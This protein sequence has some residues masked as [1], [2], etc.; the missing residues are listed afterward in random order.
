MRRKLNVKVVGSVIGVLLVASIGVH[1]LHGYQLKRNAYRL[2]ER[3]DQASA[4]KQDD[5]ALTCYQQYL[6]FAPNDADTLQK[7]VAVLDR[8]VGGE[9]VRLVLLMEQVLRAK[10]NEH[11]LRMRLVHNLIA[12]D[13]I[14]EALDHVVKLQAHWSDQAEY[15]HLLGWCQD[16]NKDHAKA[17]ESFAQAIRVNPKQIRSYALL[18][19]ILQDRLNQPDDAQKTIDDLVTANA[20]SYQA[21][22][23]RAR[24]LRRRGDDKSAQSDLA[25][26][27]KLGPDK[28]EVIFEIA[29]A[30]R[31]RGDWG[32]AVKLLKDGMKRFPDQVEF[33]RAISGVADNR[34]DAIEYLR[35]GLR[36]APQS[37]ELTILLI[38]LLIDQRQ[39]KE[40]RTKID[41][42]VKAGMKLALPNYLKARL[43]VAERE[44]SEAIRLLEGVREELGAGSEW[45]SRVHVLLG[46][47]HR[48]LGD[49]EQELQAIRR[50][51]NDEP[52]WMTANV[53][54]GA[55]LLNN[56]RL[57]EACHALEPLR[58]A[59]DLP[60]GYWILLSRARLYAQMRV[61]AAERRWDT[62]EESF[63]EAI[64]AEPK[65]AEASS[66][67][68]ELMAVRSDFAGV[69]DY[70]DALWLARVYQIAG[71]DAS[72]E[73]LLREALDQASHS[74]DTW[75]AWM[76]H[77]QHTKQHDRGVKDLD[78]LKKDLPAGRQPLT[79]ARCY[80]A[81]QMSD[82]AAKAYE[83][84]L[85]AAPDD[86]IALAYAADFARRSARA[87]DARVLY[88]RLLDP[89]LAA[90]AEYTEPARRHLASLKSKQK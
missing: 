6:S 63:A 43:A 33:Y 23:L 13:R 14:A 81:L 78:R 86:F 65:S 15:L 36:H 10:P 12:L 54:L 57:D 83:G 70:R 9:R 31:A 41:E 60:A 49:H 3:G 68:A 39:T 61:P 77:L 80:E 48:Q 42:L 44:W 67:R 25:L 28:A 40:A 30:A 24:F 62:V 56:R 73:K 87:N 35:V 75:I 90:P 59:Q 74:P 82:E 50:A 29:D 38:D 52:T 26:A 11:A 89:A 1:F 51:V 4:D 76:Q 34:Q 5:K 69:R 79:L 55:A 2:L 32:E 53:E 16:A 45:S 64:K 66:V 47:C 46:L 72:A 8:H 88:E 27:Q 18:A 58:T 20:G 84:A 22:L 19:E 85:Q 17:A 21:Y 37:S 7:Y 71:E